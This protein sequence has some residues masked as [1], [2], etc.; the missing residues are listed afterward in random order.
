MAK[1]KDLIKISD[2]PSVAGI[3]IGSRWVVFL[4]PLSKWPE[5]YKSKWFRTLRMLTALDR[6]FISTRKE[7]LAVDEWENELIKAM[8]ELRKKYIGKAGEAQ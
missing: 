1:L 5:P 4:L 3:Q 8:I 2:I 7:T 6:R